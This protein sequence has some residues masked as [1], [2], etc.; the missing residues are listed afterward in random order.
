[1]AITLI[2]NKVIAQQAVGGFSDLIV[3]KDGYLLVEDAAAVRLDG[4]GAE[5][6]IRGTVVTNS[7]GVQTK[8]IYGA[9]GVVPVQV[10]SATVTVAEGGYLGGNTAIN[11]LGANANVT[12]DGTIDSWTNGVYLQGYG[13]SIVNHGAIDAGTMGVIVQGNSLT[14]TN[15]GTITG[16]SAGLSLGGTGL[17][18][19]NTGTIV[20]EQGYAIILR[21]SADISNH[22]LIGS[23]QDG[24]IWV[25]NVAGEAGS[26]LALI[27]TGTIDAAGDAVKLDMTL[28]LVTANVL[29]TGA[30]FGNVTFG[31][32]HDVYDGREGTLR[33]VLDGGAGDDM[34]QGGAA[35]ETINGG[36]GEDDIDAGAGDDMVHGGAGADFLD[37]GVG[38]DLLMYNT[39]AAG[40]VVNMT[41]GEAWGGDAQGDVF[42]GFERLWGSSHADALTGTAQDDSIA[43]LGGDDIIVGGQGRD[44][45]RGVG[46]DDTIDGGNGRDILVGDVGADIFRYRVLGDSTASGSGRDVI[47][48]FVAGEDFID[49]SMIDPGAAPGDQAFA[50]RGSQLFS[51]SGPEVRHIELNGNTLVQVDANGDR[52]AVMSI[53]LN[54]LHVLSASDFIL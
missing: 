32:G 41:T 11:L 20:G 18:I 5:V 15:D 37:G 30:I 27:N 33:G 34:L 16:G 17:S 21:G 28:G 2:N 1:M 43:G 54:G 46:G 53:L 45:L 48:D 6:V 8:D 10:S 12:N 9:G 4:N 23:H 38:S 50:F 7:D 22:G 25:Q 51:G 44:V 13:A 52:G 42:T 40:V 26:S 47:R 39:S 14:L 24:G 29:N 31:D 3:G 49:L 36:A 19:A 35:A